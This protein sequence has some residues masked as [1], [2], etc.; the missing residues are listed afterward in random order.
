M[1]EQYQTNQLKQS[2]MLPVGA[3]QMGWQL[4]SKEGEVQMKVILKITAQHQPKNEVG[5]IT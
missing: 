4:K 1:N 5:V 3:Y 2:G